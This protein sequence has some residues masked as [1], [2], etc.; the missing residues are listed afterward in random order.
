M[1]RS[2][3][4]GFILIFVI[5]ISSILLL[6]GFSA[7]VL[8]N[9]DYEMKLIRSTV[10]KNFYIVEAA[11]QEADMLIH[12]HI[13]D[14]VILSY[15]KILELELDEQS[16]TEAFK[17]MFSSQMLYLET[18]LEDVSLYNLKSRENK[19]FTIDAQ[20]TKILIDPLIEAE[21]PVD[22]FNIKLSAVY[23]QKGVRECIEVE[24]HITGAEYGY[25][26][27]SEDLVKVKNWV[28]RQW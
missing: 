7:I 14:A 24:Y 26:R 8:S 25:Y 15:E 20:V 5:L 9:D 27:S 4:N 21:K 16:K 6:M 28:N 11:T 13:E 17:E 22:N 19:D 1:N 23:N 18:K 10:K 12:N 3:E 2:N